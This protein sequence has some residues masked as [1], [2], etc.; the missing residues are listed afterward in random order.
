MEFTFHTVYDQKAMTALAKGLGKHFV[1]SEIE[2]LEF[3]ER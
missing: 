2:D 1:P 3:W